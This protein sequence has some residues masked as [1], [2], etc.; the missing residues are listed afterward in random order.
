MFRL[1]RFFSSAQYS[2]TPQSALPSP[3]QE[4]MPR[5]FMS[6]WTAAIFSKNTPAICLESLSWRSMP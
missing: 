5:L 1:E 3:V 2:Q 4:V 6:L